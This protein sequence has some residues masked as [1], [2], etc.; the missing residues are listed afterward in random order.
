MYLLLIYGIIISD[1]YKIHK[2]KKNDTKT[3]KKGEKGNGRSELKKIHDCTSQHLCLMKNRSEMS[4]AP[5]LK[6][7]SYC[8]RLL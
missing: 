6:K 5:A 2:I 8:E 1:V 7:I 4:T 3:R